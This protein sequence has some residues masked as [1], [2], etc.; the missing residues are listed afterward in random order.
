[1]STKQ[2]TRRGFLG[3]IA[4][5]AAAP[6]IATKALSSPA[7][8]RL[9]A[10]DAQFSCSAKDLAQAL[11]RVGSSATEAGVSFDELTGHVVAAQRTTGRSGTVIGNALKNVY[12]RAARAQAGT[13]RDGADLLR[14][15]SANWSNM[16]AAERRNVAEQL[17]GVYQANLARSLFV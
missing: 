7:A 11:E 8:E 6:F 15:I 17:G 14:T 13:G 3:L 5:L 10:V 1:M 4:A 9:A 16:S 12:T 2:T